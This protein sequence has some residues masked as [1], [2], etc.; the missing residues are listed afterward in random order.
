MCNATKPQNA[1]EQLT[2]DDKLTILLYG[3]GDFE[4]TGIMC[5]VITEYMRQETDYSP[6]QI[7]E[8]QGHRRQNWYFWQRDHPDFLTWWNKVIE[9]VIKEE[10]LSGMYL[11][12]IKRAG[13]HDT[14]AA[15]LI[16]QRYDPKYTERSQQDTRHSFQ[17]YEPKAAEDS[18][19]R[20]RKALAEQSQALPVVEVDAREALPEAPPSNAVAPDENTHPE[21]MSPIAPLSPPSTPALQA[22]SQS[23]EHVEPEP[24]PVDNDKTLDSKPITQQ[25][26]GRGV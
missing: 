5:R 26:P 20:Q 11:Q 1:I 4:P 9:N 7:L 23:A 24:A 21:P 22:Q 8:R 18:R 12:L 14:G 2:N 6:M 10:Y 16:A 15:K 13:T 25:D 3:Y 19:E 17:G